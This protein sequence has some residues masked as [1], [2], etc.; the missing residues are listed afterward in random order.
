MRS[1]YRWMKITAISLVG[2]VLTAVVVLDAVVSAYP[3]LTML[4]RHQI[5]QPVLYGLVRRILGS[6][7][8]EAILP[9][10][11]AQTARARSGSKLVVAIEPSPPR[12]SRDMR[13]HASITYSYGADL[14]RPTY[15]DFRYGGGVGCRSSEIKYDP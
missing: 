4:A 13:C 12:K 6:R 11:L 7:S 14:R 2:V 9:I 15:E 3:G 10:L 1:Q 8:D 5:A